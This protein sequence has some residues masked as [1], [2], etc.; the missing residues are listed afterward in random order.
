MHY[1]IMLKTNDKLRL[2]SIDPGISNFCYVIGECDADY[3]NLS[4]LYGEVI[5]IRDLNCNRNQCTLRHD[6]R[7]STWVRHFIHHKHD[8]MEDA[9]TVIIEH[10]PIGGLGAIEQVL[11][12]RL[13][14]KA[15]LCEPSS[16]HKYFGVGGKHIKDLEQRREWRKKAVI[17]IA[18]KYV[19]TDM[20]D[21]IESYKH[22]DWKRDQMQHICDAICQM[23]YMV[24]KKKRE[25]DENKR[26]DAISSKIIKSKGITFKEMTEKFMYVGKK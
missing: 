23:K 3:D 8:I 11:F 17:K 2:V 6:N 13:G 14:E 4:I 26:L 22:V 19:E 7:E 24:S 20:K 15:I 25:I 21:K 1:I 9:T 16:M 12:D 5:D 10:Q 18:M